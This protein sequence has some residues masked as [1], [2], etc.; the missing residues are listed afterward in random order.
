MEGPGVAA[1]PFPLVLGRNPAKAVE[2]DTTV[3]EPHAFRFQET[4]LQPS[5]RAF[6]DPACPLYHAPPRQSLAM[7]TQDRPH[8]AGGPGPACKDRHRPVREHPPLGDSLDDREDT[9]S[10]F[11]HVM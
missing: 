7:G 1:W 4:A 6:G 2:V 3:D 10:E 5:G 9:L 11:T 8:A